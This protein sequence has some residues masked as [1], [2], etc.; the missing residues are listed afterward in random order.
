M[1][2]MFYKD[3]FCNIPVTQFSSQGHARNFPA[4]S[5]SRS[6]ERLTLVVDETR[7]VVEAELFRIQPNTMLGR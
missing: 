4:N 1:L 6:G 3:T 2:V 5:S 7:F